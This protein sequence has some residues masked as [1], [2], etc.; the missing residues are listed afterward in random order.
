MPGDDEVARGVDLPIDAASQGWSGSGRVDRRD[1][2][3][4]NM[5]RR[6]LHAAGQDDPVAANDER[7]G[8][9]HASL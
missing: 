5:D 6:G 2:P 1:A 7:G 3:I 4:A 9:F 8:V